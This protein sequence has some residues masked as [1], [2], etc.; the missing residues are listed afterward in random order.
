MKRITTIIKAMTR[1]RAAQGDADH[2]PASPSL[3]TIV[4][5]GGGMAAHRFCRQLVAQGGLRRYRLMVFTDE[6]SAPYDRVKLTDFF[7]T[8]NPDNLLLAPPDWYRQHGIELRLGEAVTK[9]DPVQQI[10]HTA[11]SAVVHY[12]HL[13]LATGSHPFVPSIDGIHQDDVFVYRTLEDLQAILARS[14]SA[15]R[16]AVIGGGLLGLE[17]ARALLD[18]G[19]ETTVVEMA[20]Y[21]MPRQL[22][23]EGAALLLTEMATPGVNILLGHQTSRIEKTRAGLMLCFREHDTLTVDMVVVS[24]GITPRG[25]LAVDAG[26]ACTP[27]GAAIV[28]NHLQTSDPN[29]YAIG[30]CAAYGGQVFGL[31]APAYAMADVVAHRLMGKTTS[32]T[33]ADLSTRLKLLGVD[34]S[35]IGDY[36]QPSDSLIYR[37]AGVYRKLALR[38]G[39]LVGALAVGSWHQIG[40]IQAAAQDETRLSKRQLDRFEHAGDLWPGSAPP[41]SAWPDE[42][43]VCNCFKVTKGT[44]VAAQRAGALSVEALAKATSASTLCGSCQP[45]L[46]ELAGVTPYAVTTPDPASRALKWTAVAALIAAILLATL[47]PLPITNSIQHWWHD[48]EACRRWGVTKQTTGY[49]LM[50]L[51]C[52]A[53]GLSLRKRWSRF[54]FGAFR[55]WRTAHALLGLGTLVGLVAHTGLRFGSNLNFALMSIFVVLNLVGAFAGWVAAVESKGTGRLAQWARRW[56]PLVAFA[57]L[58]LFWPLP[59]LLTFHILASYYY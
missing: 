10:L 37:A 30:E 47:P 57:H 33:G 24:A 45:L 58:L 4:V 56:R 15:R 21:L 39:H 50:G 3:A 54:S 49:M 1:K 19:L 38:Q 8:R 40:Q 41:I 5:V 20:D 31:A 46:V 32:F 44:L 6:S 7:R 2:D 43:L 29:I 11:F 9:I 13:V 42:R 18:L 17:A 59:V 27:R 12:D 14:Q 55:S 25:E 16:A 53:L 28:D 22:D 48:V 23:P 51:T 52:I 26:L 36:L 35:V 34:V